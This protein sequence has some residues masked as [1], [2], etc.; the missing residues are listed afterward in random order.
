MSQRE[1]L[2]RRRFL[3]LA[4]LSPLA[5]AACGQTLAGQSSSPSGAASKPAGSANAGAPS[6]A[7]ATSGSAAASPS[8]AASAASKPSAST[9]LASGL[10]PPAQT[11]AVFNT[12][13]KD[14]TLVDAAKNEVADTK[15]L[16]AAIR[17]LGE[18]QDYWDGKLVWTYDFPNNKLA[19]LGID[20]TTWQ[21]AKTYQAGNG[22]GHSVVLSQDRKIASINVAGDNKILSFDTAS[23][24]QVASFDS[25]KFPCDLDNSTDYKVLYT[26]ERD[27]D[28]V[29]ALDAATLKLIKRVSFPT[30]NKPHMLRVSPDGQ[31]IWVQEAA[32]GNNVVL[33]ASDL[34]VLA[35]EK[36]GNTPVNN[37]WTPDGRF[38]IVTN[39]GETTVSLF[40]A[41]T[42]KLIKTI[43]V[44]QG[45]S[46]VSFRQDGKFAYVS[47]TGANA[48]AV[49][50]TATWTVAKTVKTG[51]MPQGVIILPPSP[52]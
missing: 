11:I 10:T 30:G 46:V 45:P 7:P 23:G 6:S 50:D 18:E 15:P 36:S 32:A 47:L 38:S 39:S 35:R 34:S 2:T 20:P 14:V 37:A 28:T 26:P 42:Y 13:S 8:I 43:E 40:D 24:N 33:K 5:L 21:V 49:I 41:Q 25:G 31:T 16:G 22:P 1:P 27:Q 19:M 3:Y 52:R 9:A 12:G 44:G 48:L 4:G 51:Q 17:W 29:A